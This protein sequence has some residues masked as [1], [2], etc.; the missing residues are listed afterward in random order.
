MR[1]MKQI[2]F[3]ATLLGALFV[4]QVSN[5]QS[6]GHVG[7]RQKNQKARIHQGMRSGTLN[8]GEAMRLR[9]Q[10]SKVRHY[11]QMALADGRVT[12]G[13]RRLLRSE[14][15]RAHHN[16]YRSKHN[17]KYA[18]KY[19]KGGQYGKK[20]NKKGYKSGNNNRDWRYDYQSWDRGIGLSR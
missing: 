4:A 19:G 14:Q 5:A 1:F 9:A 2:I 8:K 20:Y 13:E 18:A 3:A 17:G 15:M 16:I 6:R 7:E 10:Q 12:P 11:K